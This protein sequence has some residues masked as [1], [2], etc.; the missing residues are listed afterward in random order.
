MAVN[1]MVLICPVCKVGK[2]IAK[3]YTISSWNMND[4]DLT[5]DFMQRHLCCAAMDGLKIPFELRYDNFGP[6]DWEYEHLKD[7]K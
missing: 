7:P 2:S 6:Q 3:Y 5:N 4:S 1:R